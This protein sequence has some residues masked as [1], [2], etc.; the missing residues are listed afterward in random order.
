LAPLAGVAL[1]WLGGQLARFSTGLLA[2]WSHVLV[3]TG[4]VVWALGWQASIA[5]PQ[6]QLLTRADETAMAWIRQ[7]TPP[8]AAFF[9]NSFPAYGN[10]LFAG[11]D[12]GWWLSFLTGRQSSLPPLTYGSEAAED[13]D[14]RQDVF[15]FN[16][17]MREAL[18]RDPNEA[19]VA[20]KAAGYRYLYNGA[21]ANPNDEPITQADLSRFPA[22]ELV[23]DQDGVQIWRLR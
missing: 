6:F 17:S 12:G 1:A 20:L 22:Y 14:F 8:D 19:A 15:R 10:T 13:P 9:V 5:E 3:G 2:T 7:E 18:L 21:A 16:S 11:S 4:L 23:Y